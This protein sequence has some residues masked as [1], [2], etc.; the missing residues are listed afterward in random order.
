M[1]TQQITVEDFEQRI[2][3]VNADKAR[4]GRNEIFRNSN[5][6]KIALQMIEQPGTK[7]FPDRSGRNFKTGYCHDV[8]YLFKLIGVKSWV[9]NDCT[10]SPRGGV[11]GNFV[12]IAVDQDNQ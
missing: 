7:I 9:A 6:Y 11:T 10:R 12:V 4:I 5:A 8:V 1:K 2:D 3:K